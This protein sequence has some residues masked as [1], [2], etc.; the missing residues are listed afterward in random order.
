MSSSFRLIPL[1]FCNFQCKLSTLF[2]LKAEKSVFRFRQACSSPCQP[3]FKS[4]I[5]EDLRRTFPDNSNFHGGSQS[6][7]LMGSL[8][9]VLEAFASFRPDPGYCQG[10]TTMGCLPKGFL[11]Y[12]LG[13]FS[14]IKIIHKRYQIL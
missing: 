3:D 9:L 5:F 14:T 2:N 6:E 10:K 13:F 12:D 8:K 7:R 1:P 11:F 4:V